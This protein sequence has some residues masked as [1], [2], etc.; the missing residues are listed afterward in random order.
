MDPL[1]RPEFGWL[2]S[3][4]PILAEDVMKRFALCLLLS[5][6]PSLAQA[7]VGFISTI[8]GTG[9]SGP[10]GDGGPATSASLGTM[11]TRSPSSP[12]AW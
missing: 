9:T 4:N 5:T 12:G 7:Q 11:P 2:R 6:L 10:N 8:A 1:A 3:A